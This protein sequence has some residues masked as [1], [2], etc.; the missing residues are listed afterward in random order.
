MSISLNTTYSCLLAQCVLLLGPLVFSGLFS[1]SSF[2]ILICTT[3][4]W[5]QIFANSNHCRRHCHNLKTHN[6]YFHYSSVGTVILQMGIAALKK[7]KF[8]KAKFLVKTKIITFLSGSW[9][10]KEKTGARNIFLAYHVSQERESRIGDRV[11]L[12]FMISFF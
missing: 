7:F 4:A 2:R 10:L 9:K 3:S 6:I 1:H 12:S 5:S 11:L 8:G